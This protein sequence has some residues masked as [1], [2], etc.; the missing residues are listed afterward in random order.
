MAQVKKGP[1]GKVLKR[2]ID[3]AIIFSRSWHFFWKKGEWTEFVLRF[4]L[5]DK[6]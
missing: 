6:S 1:K 4:T 5:F 2:F 3:P